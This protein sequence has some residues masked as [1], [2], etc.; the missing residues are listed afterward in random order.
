M[1]KENLF[2]FGGQDE[3]GAQSYAMYRV[4][5]PL[6]ENYATA[7]PKWM[8]WDSELPYNKNRTCTFFNGSIYIYQLGSNTLGR[9]NEEDAEKGL[10]YW[11]VFKTARL[12]S[13]KAKQLQEEELRPKNAKRARVQHTGHIAAKMPKSYSVNTFQEG[14]VLSYVQDFQRVFEEL[15]P[16]RRPLYLTPRNECGV[17]KFVCTT[18]RPTSLNYTE[19]YDL[20]GCA[21]FVADY[22]AYEELEDPLV[23][24][25][26]RLEWCDEV[27]TRCDAV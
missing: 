17:P 27:M 19:L 11:D 8:E 16:H 4:A 21:Q 23:S 5:L 3:L 7:K 22:L 24:T 2:L 26:T 9:V 14:R 1:W 20:D 6:G 25:S 18:L 15:Y 12:E 13:L 10:V